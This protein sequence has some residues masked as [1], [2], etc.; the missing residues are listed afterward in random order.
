M[1]RAQSAEVTAVRERLKAAAKGTGPGTRRAAAQLREDL[2]QWHRWALDGVALPR[3]PR[4]IR[5][6]L[7]KPAPCAKAKRSKNKIA[8]NVKTVSGRCY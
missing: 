7:A 3:L 6:G 1:N 5:V 8:E 4:R 2:A